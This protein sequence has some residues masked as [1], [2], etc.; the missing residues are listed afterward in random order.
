[1]NAREEE[2]K[3]IG[4][5]LVG[6]DAIE[7]VTGQTKYAADFSL[8]G[9][10]HGKILRSKYPHARIKRIDISKAEKLDGVLCVLTHKDVPNNT[11][12]SRF[13]QTREVGGFEGIFRILAEDKVRYFGEAVALVAAETEEIAEKAIEAIEVE[14]EELEGIF[15]PEEAM[16]PKAPRIGE[17]KENVIAKF[18]IRKGNIEKGFEDAD[19]VV[20]NE[21]K[22]QFMDHAYMEPEA[23]VAWVEDDG[24]IT[25][26]V[27]TQV[28]EH[29]REIAHV[30]GI[31]ESKVRVITPKLGGGFGGK[32][33]ITVEYYLALLARKTG[34][35]I[36]LVQS[37][38]ESLSSRGKRHPYK[39][40][41]KTGAKKSG[42]IVALEAELISDAGA[43]M[44]LSPW[45]LLYSTIN[46]TG[47]YNIPNVKIDSYA[48]LTNNPPSTAMRTFGAGQVCIAYEQQLDELAKKLGMDSA[49]LRKKNYLKKGDTL[50][51]GRK[52][53]NCVA[54]PELTDKVLKALGEKPEPSDPKKLI[55]RGLASSMTSYGRMIFLHDT[56]RSKV[57][58]ELD[59]SITIECGVQDLGGGQEASLCQIVSEVFRV[60]LNK[61]KII[62]GDSSATPLAGTTTA[63][64]QLYM[65]GN[66]TY[67]AAMKVRD[68]LLN[69]ASEILGVDK[70]E[71]IM[72][73]EK[74]EVKG[75]DEGIS[76]RDVAVA[77]AGDGA[78]LFCEAQFNADFGE[79]PDFK[80]GQGKVF[81]DYTYGTTGAIVEIDIET[82]E[83][84][85]KKLVSAFDVGKTI[86]PL[87][88]EG[89]IEGGAVMGTGWALTEDMKIEGGI[90]K[91]QSLAEYIIP[92]SVDVPDVKSIIIENR[93]GL[94]PFGARGIGEPAL[95]PVAP[96]II[97]AIAD[98]LGKRIKEL[99]I[100]SEKILLSCKAV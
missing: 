45:V 30:L 59:G 50:A 9:M 36:K 1:M 82:G 71:L 8:P 96:A 10:V 4:K 33:D 22:T 90:P 93:D 16:D 87:R 6:H 17:G 43:Y 58:V 39:L 7:K 53:T 24:S 91:A 79:V 21:Y 89:Q 88:V 51:N 85:V 27:S 100:T 11:I 52:I 25:I 80:T 68:N 66:A 2:F 65:S 73:D 41:Y 31:P 77:C 92:T 5:R 23:G 81:P 75:R 18:R 94:G 61:I 64:R 46:S 63:T 20:E 95:T 55:G 56:S 3:S 69:K 13:G 54:L 67:K 49:E 86:N 70:S 72:E 15:D 57:R 76:L 98:A 48:V 62:S 19:V 26:R 47:P 97:N 44:T 28:I 42:E 38:E 34:R 83:V 60:P 84:E 37:R 12:V 14:Y 74:I 40:R 99:P 78:E 29:Y 35:P 32:E